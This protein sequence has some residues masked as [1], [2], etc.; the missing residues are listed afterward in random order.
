MVGTSAKG[1]A[2]V[3]GGSGDIGAQ[4]VRRLA[5]SGHAVVIGY[6]T[7]RN[8][9]EELSQEIASAGSP[10][11]AVAIDVTDSSSVENAFAEI[12]STLADVTI[13]VNNAG[14]RADGLIAG[15]EDD[16]WA[17]VIDTNLSSAF[18][19]SRRALGPMLRARGGRI[20]NV[21]SVLASRSIA[22]TG[23][24]AAAKSGLLGLTRTLA[25]EVARRGITVNAVCPGLVSTAMTEQLGHFD[26]SVQRAVPMGRPAELQEIAECIAFLAS[27]SAEYITGQ[28]IAVDGGLS[29][30]AFSLR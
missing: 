27:D 1:C 15:I 20:I 30:Q 19:T 3:T 13:L 11:R 2:F 9:A 22:G 24:Y 12:E 17:R 10:A 25:I 6:A 21:S 4:I 26:Q 18:R 29:A 8:R 14:I 7:Q 28:A 16:E 23:S 5:K